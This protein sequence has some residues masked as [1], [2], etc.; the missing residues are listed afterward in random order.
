ML[1]G[2]IAKVDGGYP[3]Y[4]GS[5]INLGYLL[6]LACESLNHYSEM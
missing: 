1:L 4:D 2:P 5:Y 6:A 3:V